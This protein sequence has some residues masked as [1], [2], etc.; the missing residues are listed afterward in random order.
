MGAGG[1]GGA[2][3]GGGD[4]GG[5]DGGGGDGGGG[6]GGGGEGGGGGDGGFGPGGFGPGG[7]FL[8]VLLPLNTA[9]TIPPTTPNTTITLIVINKIVLVLLDLVFIY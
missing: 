7:G 3:G 8:C 2:G 9:Y 5:G 1:A 4:G 6:E